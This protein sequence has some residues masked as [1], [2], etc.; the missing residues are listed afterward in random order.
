MDEDSSAS[1]DGFK[2]KRQCIRERIKADFQIPGLRRHD[3]GK[4]CAIV[5]NSD[6]C[7]F[8]GVNQFTVVHR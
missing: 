6:L 2:R 4:R 7:Q 5:F 1:R 8:L 3:V